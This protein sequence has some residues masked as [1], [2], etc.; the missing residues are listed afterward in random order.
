MTKDQICKAANEKFEDNSFAYKGF[1]R[2]AEWRINSVWHSDNEVPKKH[3]DLMIELDTGFHICIF[4][5]GYNFLG[6]YDYMGF[7][8]FEVIRWAYL[9][10][11]LPNMEE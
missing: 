7:V 10:D 1:I 3:E 11:L 4:E 6:Y 8:S 9:K 5:D 2:G